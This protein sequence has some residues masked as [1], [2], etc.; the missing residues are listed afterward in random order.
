MPANEQLTH[1]L[2][3]AL[4]PLEQVEEIKMFNGIAFLVNGKMCIC[5][6]NDE[7]L[8]R[9]DPSLQETLMERPGCR[10]ML[11]R[12]KALTGYVYVHQE[13]VKTKKDFDYWVALCLAYNQ[14]AKASKKKRTAT[15]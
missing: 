6:S 10:P 5:V 14:V 7:L 2:R 9:I 3:A 13:F 1:R 15:K 12:D 11:R 8:C 4:A